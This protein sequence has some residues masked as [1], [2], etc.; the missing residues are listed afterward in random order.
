ML[1]RHPWV[2]VS[3][4]AAGLAA[5][6]G[7]GTLHD[8]GHADSLLPVLVSTQRWTPFFWGQDRFGMLIPLLAMPFRHPLVNMLVQG[9]LTTVAALLAPF[10]VAR[11]LTGRRGE[12]IAIGACTNALLLWIATP[13]VR[14]D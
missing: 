7:L 14:F 5:W 8:F 4:L 10:V 6:M 11:F 3:L 9:W 12:W 2:I 1:H 13:V